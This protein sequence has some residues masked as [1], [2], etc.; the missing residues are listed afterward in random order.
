M[1]RDAEANNSDSPDKYP[2][3]TAEKEGADQEPAT[4]SPS[5]TRLD[6]QLRLWG[7]WGQERLKDAGVGICDSSATS[8]QI[9]KNLI[10]SG[11]KSVLM[12][13]TAKVRQSDIGNNFF[14]EQA[15][16]GKTRAEESGKL[17]EQLTSTFK[18][19]P[20]YWHDWEFYNEDFWCELEDI[21]ALADWNAFI[22][23][24]MVK[25]DEEVT[26]RFGWGF[27]VPT[28]SVQTCGL[29]ASIRLQ[30]RELYVFQTPSDSF[31]DLRLDCPFPS[32]STFANSFEMDKMNHREHAHVPA[33]AIIVH[34]LER[35]K[36][37]HDGK[38]PQDSTQRAELKEMILAEKRDVDEENFDEAVNLI[39][40]ACQPTEV[41]THIQELFDD[42][43]CDKAPW[44]DGSFWLLVKTLREFVKRDPNHQLPLS[45]AIPDMKS[46]TKNYVKMESIYRQKASEDLQ[47]FNSILDDV[48]DSSEPDDDDNDDDNGETETES[49]FHHYG[50]EYQLSSEMIETFVKNCA[51]IR[52]IRGS[53]YTNDQPKDLMLKF[54]KEC[55]P[56]NQEFTANWFLGFQALSAYRLAKQGEYPG[57]R[58][59]QEEH[60][61]NSLSEIALKDLIRRGWDKDEK[62]VPEKLAKVLKEMVR[63]SGSELPHISSIVGGLVSQEVI[64]MTT[65]RYVP[66]NGICIFDGYRST[67]GVLE[68]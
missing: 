55:E 60:D 7:N 15:S 4:I 30:I 31:V 41:P 37:K 63:S 61:F 27:N 6:R 35:F 46:N 34:Y 2:K 26:S 50:P 68:F 13:D 11:A 19:H 57:M 59:G 8:T 49:G 48:K 10:L 33:V 52:L 18:Y 54:S 56:G 23:V 16:L 65:G 43:Y 14:L 17:L 21:D 42:P 36:S 51:H 24:R 44:F 3:C 58:K 32:L 12:M 67:T 38:L 28:F 25:A 1:K 64:K 29:V 20:V 47:T 40:N 9:A 22:G 39:G 53:K 45:G 62:K 5:S 66:M